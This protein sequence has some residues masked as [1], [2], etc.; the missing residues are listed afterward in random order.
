[1]LFAATPPTEVN[2]PA[3]TTSPFARCV[4]ADTGPGVPPPSGVHAVPV[5]RARWPTATAPDVVKKPPATRSPL[6]STSSD[7]TAPSKPAP[8]GSQVRAIGSYATTFGAAMLPAP[9]KSPPNTTSIGSGPAPSGSHVTVACTRFAGDVRPP[10][11]SH[12][13]GH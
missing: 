7:I 9:T 1:M 10:A 12:C 6:P 11:A 8:I 4:I 3:T 13:S 2:R 5:H